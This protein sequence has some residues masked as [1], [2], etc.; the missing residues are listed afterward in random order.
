MTRM[1]DLKSIAADIEQPKT[2]IDSNDPHKMIQT[3]TAQG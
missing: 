2:A 1:R 3:R